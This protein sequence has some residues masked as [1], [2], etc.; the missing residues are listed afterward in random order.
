[1]VDDSIPYR[2]A[3]TASILL[4]LFYFAPTFENG[5]HQPFRAVATRCKVTTF[6]LDKKFHDES[7]RGNGSDGPLHNDIVKRR[8]EFAVMHKRQKVASIEARTKE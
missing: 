5:R 7:V 8:S 4:Q 3:L 6:S 2:S 1:M